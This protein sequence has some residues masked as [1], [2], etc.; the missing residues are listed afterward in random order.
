MSKK[1]DLDFDDITKP[2]IKK[3]ER[4]VKEP[5]KKPNNGFKLAIYYLGG[6]VKLLDM[7]NATNE[8]FVEWASRFVPNMNLP[9]TS[10]NEVKRKD[11]LENILKFH[12]YN[13]NM[14]KNKN[15]EYTN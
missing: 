13:I 3:V 4:T 8:E 9:L 6:K 10:Y 12:Y 15:L 1:D 5:E 11:I 7:S 14:K 2:I